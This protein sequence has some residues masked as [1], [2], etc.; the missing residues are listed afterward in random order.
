MQKKRSTKKNYGILILLR[1][2]NQ[3]MQK[4]PQQKKTNFGILT[5]PQ[6]LKQPG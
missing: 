3:Q 6:R 1:R 2:L 4:R 5:L